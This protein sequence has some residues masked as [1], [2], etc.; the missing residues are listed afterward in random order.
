MLRVCYLIQCQVQEKQY[1]QG[2]LKAPP[3]GGQGHTPPAQPL[4]TQSQG[5]HTGCTLNALTPKQQ[6]L[7]TASLAVSNVCNIAWLL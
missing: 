7:H 4:G 5:L 6:Q 1:H 2:G 3:Q